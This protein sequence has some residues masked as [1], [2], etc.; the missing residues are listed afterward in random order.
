MKSAESISLRREDIDQR[1]RVIWDNLIGG[2]AALSTWQ[3]VT[4]AV[5][6]DRLDG[7][8][9]LLQSVVISCR[10]E[11]IMALARIF[12]P[13]DRR[14]DHASLSALLDLVAQNPEV[15]V[16]A[17]TRESVIEVVEDKKKWIK[18][19]NLA[20]R[21]RRIRNKV[22]AHSDLQG[23]GDRQSVTAVW[24]SMAEVEACYEEVLE[25]VNVFQGHLKD[26]EWILGDIKPD[27]IDDFNRLFKAPLDAHAAW[28]A[29]R[30]ARGA[31]TP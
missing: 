2:W 12:D 19:H 4:E 15:F 9:W 16:H 29:K 14:H 11:A 24:I 30:D 17:P 20:G 22:L 1:F 28:K 7:H 5:N 3:V 6:E 10:H 31:L 27:V 18:E 21:I 23:V 8:S 13:R 25:V 26:C